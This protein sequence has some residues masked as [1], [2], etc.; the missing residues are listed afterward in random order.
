VNPKG[1][2]DAPAGTVVRISVEPNIKPKL[3]EL[4]LDETSFG[5]HPDPEVRDFVYYTNDHDGISIEVNETEGTVTTV[6]YSP[7][8]TDQHLACPEVD[9]SLKDLGMVAHKVDEYFASP[10]DIQEER[11]DK[12]ASL[13]LVTQPPPATS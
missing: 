1:G 8:I 13:L 10:A 7:S 4:K 9:S 12:L 2:W 5:R 6:T 3:A 11:L